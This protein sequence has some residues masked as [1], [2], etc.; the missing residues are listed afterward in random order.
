MKKIFFNR[1]CLAACL[2]AAVTLVSCKE[3]PNNADNNDPNN[4]ENNDPNNNN[5][6]KPGPAVDLTPEQSKQYLGE[7]GDEFLTYFNPDDQKAHVQLIQY[8]GET[9]GDYS[10][11]SEFS[12]EYPMAPMRRVAQALRKAD[13]FA[14]ASAA[15]PVV[16]NYDNYTGVYKASGTRW[17]RVGDASSIKFQIQDQ[18][19]QSGFF[20]ILREGNEQDVILGDPMPSN[21]VVNVPRTLTARLTVGSTTYFSVTKTST[22]EMNKAYDVK[23][24]GDFANVNVNMSMNAQNSN[25]ILGGTLSV[26]GKQLVSAKGTVNG[27]DMCNFNQL[28]LIERPGDIDRFFQTMEVE[29]SIL[30]KVKVMG[31]AKNFGTLAD[32]DG[33]AEFGDEYYYEYRTEN[34]AVVAVKKAIDTIQAN[35]DIN[36]WMK[37]KAQCKLGYMPKIW[38]SEYGAYGDVEA[39]PVLQ[40][41][42][43]TSYEFEE[44]F[45]E[46]AFKSLINN[47]DFLIR[48]YERLI[49]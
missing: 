2:A 45:T 30:G 18:K 6:D 17:V 41:T 43:G 10:A 35:M 36:L 34:E 33:Y 15:A 32:V 5:G 7:V 12:K 13:Y 29:A 37:G 44:F 48:A 21:L 16:Y 25:A 9:Y 4:T 27:R 42:D 40:F 14:A 26:G 8:L 11:P 49:N 24:T 20:E 38:N 39:V 46:T 47:F 22:L 19:G 31:T 28:T 23:V 1:L 3:D